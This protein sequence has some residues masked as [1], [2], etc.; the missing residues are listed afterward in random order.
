[1][2]LSVV[3][4]GDQ[5]VLFSKQWRAPGR[6]SRYLSP[7]VG[8]AL[9]FLGLTPDELGGLAV[10]RGPGGFTGLR[11]TIAFAQGLS[12]SAGPLLAGLDYLPLLAS[13]PGPQLDGTLAVAV[14][15]RMREIYVQAF[16]C[17]GVEPLAGPAVLRVEDLPEA[18][19][20]LPGPVR[21]IGG[22][23]RRNDAYFAERLGETA[24]LP[25]VWDEPSPEQLARAA[26]DARY[27]TAPIRPLYLRPSD[28][29]ENLAGIAAL[30]GLDV[31]EAERRLDQ[32]VR[33]IS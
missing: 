28:A 12:L 1:M 32:A 4:A 2:L 24:L 30:R 11:M 9:E 3:A 18:L 19:A 29:E 21:L 15:S 22:G 6:A 10:V 13:G 14:H 7:A 27:S 31:E 23:L 8:E 26:I 20:R 33:K 25:S 16:S 17:P 5:G